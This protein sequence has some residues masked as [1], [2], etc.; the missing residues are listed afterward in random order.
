MA[1][2]R[3][4]VASLMG[5]DPANY[6][7][8]DN[9]TT[10]ASTVALHVASKFQSGEYKAGDRILVTRWMYDS[11]FKA[12]HHYCGQHGAVFVIVDLPGPPIA[13]IDAVTE[14][15]RAA[16]AKLND[17]WTG[18]DD[19]TGVTTGRF[20]SLPLHPHER[21]PIRLACLDHI[22]SACPYTLPLGLICPLL[23]AA[24]VQEIFVD[25]AHVP[26]QL[27]VDVTQTGADYYTGNLHKWCYTPPA[28]AFL[29]VKSTANLAAMHY[30]VISHSM[31]GGL[32]EEA[33]FVGTRDYSMYAAVPAA[34]AFHRSFESPSVYEYTHDLVTRAAQM[35]A[36]AW[37]TELGQPADG[38]CGSLMMVGLPPAVGS[39]LEE[40]GELVSNLNS[41]HGIWT[42]GGGC[43]GDDGKL[44]MRLSAAA[45]N[46]LEEFEKL[47]DAV[48]DLTSG[49][50]GGKL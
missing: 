1:L 36:E 31:N 25:G 45:Y 26:G 34:I 6:C 8:L 19:R 33:G 22:P 5:G 32:V 11:C 24:G 46:S 39:S 17:P 29:W 27:E 30:P 12:F 44:Y 37:G 16:L 40:L 20:G 35:L 50:K 42:W 23:R 15:F 38:S 41:E 4:A 21:A 7:L 3:G 47:R 28:V 49:A 2:A 9:A 43:L 18:F 48:L 13:S 14:A 10:A